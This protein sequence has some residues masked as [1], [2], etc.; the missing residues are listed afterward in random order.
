MGACKLAKSAR[1]RAGDDAVYS[2]P[3]RCDLAAVGRDQSAAGRTAWLGDVGRTFQLQ[4]HDPA[5]RSRRWCTGMCT[6][7]LDTTDGN[8]N[9]PDRWA[10]AICHNSQASVAVV[11]PSSLLRRVQNVRL[12]RSEIGNRR[13]IERQRTTLGVIDL[14]SSRYCR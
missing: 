4:Q 10:A 6:W 13:Y 3:R 7:C 5:A 12:H 8:G 2:A 9:L 14:I 1:R 11:R